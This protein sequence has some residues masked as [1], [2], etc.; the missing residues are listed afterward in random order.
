MTSVQSF[1]ARSTSMS[2]AIFQRENSFHV[3]Y[4][5]WI[6]DCDCLS[7]RSESFVLATPVFNLGCLWSFGGRRRSPGME[8]F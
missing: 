8:I 7:Y 1:L 6:R 4:S 2:V 5:K 3:F